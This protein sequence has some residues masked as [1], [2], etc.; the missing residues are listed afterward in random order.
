MELFKLFSRSLSIK[1]LNINLL[2]D[3]NLRIKFVFNYDYDDEEW[4]KKV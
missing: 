2:W 3:S 1:V 4:Y